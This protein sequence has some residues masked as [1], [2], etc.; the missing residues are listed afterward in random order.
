[1]EGE[2]IVFR[3]RNLFAYSCQ[4][5]ETPALVLVAPDSTGTGYNAQ[6]NHITALDEIVRFYEPVKK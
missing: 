6:S 2:D 4:K 5:R 1:M 3:T